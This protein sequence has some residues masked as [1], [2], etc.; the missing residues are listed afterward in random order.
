MPR[1]MVYQKEVRAVPLPKTTFRAKPP[2][3]LDKNL[4]HYRKLNAV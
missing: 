1:R 3:L 4:H 2:E